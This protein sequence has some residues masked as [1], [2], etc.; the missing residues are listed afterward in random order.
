MYKTFHWVPAGSIN[1][2][3]ARLVVNRNHG[4]GQFPLEPLTHAETQKR[5]RLQK[6]S[7]SQKKKKKKGR[8]RHS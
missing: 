4:T 5:V 2:N 6:A 1:R 3:T 7:F 8:D